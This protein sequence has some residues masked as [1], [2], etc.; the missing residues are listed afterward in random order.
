[1]TTP[2]I[3][4]HGHD[5][6]EETTNSAESLFSMIS[7]LHSISQSFPIT[8]SSTPSPPIYVQTPTI[9]SPISIF[10]IG[11]D[12]IYPDQEHVRTPVELNISS[13]PYSKENNENSESCIICSEEYIVGVD[14][15]TL[16]CSHTFHTSCI[17]EWGCYKQDCP[18]CRTNIP[19]FSQLE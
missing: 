3:T 12:A 9:N 10:I 17:K 18:I 7:T 16:D 19:H 4:I 15:T 13:Q 2:R 8:P 1:M 6:P 11:E 14:V 5:F